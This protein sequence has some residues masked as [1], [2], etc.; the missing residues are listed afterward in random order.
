MKPLALFLAC[1]TG[2]CIS[3]HA[4]QTVSVD[5][6]DAKLSYAWDDA[7]HVTKQQVKDALK[8]G[9]YEGK[10]DGKKEAPTGSTRHYGDCYSSR[11]YSSMYLQQAYKDAYTKGYKQFAGRAPYWDDRIEIGSGTD[12]CR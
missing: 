12:C 9:F 5:L 1:I 8:T 2:L 3:A 4:Q 10:C 11:S 6:G 7:A